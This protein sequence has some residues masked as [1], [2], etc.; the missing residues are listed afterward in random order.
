VLPFRV[1]DRIAGR[2]DLKADRKNSQ[3]LV[4]NAHEEDS[5]DI[6]HCCQ[7]LNTELH[8]LKDW[9]GLDE[10]RVEENNHFSR[11]LGKTVH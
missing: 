8:A 6:D 5:I 3:L 2:V 7:E 11:R 9:L 10:V 4:L 1:G